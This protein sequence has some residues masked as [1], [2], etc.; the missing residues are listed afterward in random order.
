MP[1]TRWYNAICLS[2]SMV[3]KGRT[4]DLLKTSALLTLEIKDGGIR[5]KRLKQR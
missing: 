3:D 2:R 5:N 4:S 1:T